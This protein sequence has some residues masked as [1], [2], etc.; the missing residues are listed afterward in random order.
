MDRTENV[1]SNSSTVIGYVSFAVGLCLLSRCI[2]V[3]V[4]SVSAVLALRC[5]VM[6]WLY[7]IILRKLCLGDKHPCIVIR[8]LFKNL[9]QRP[10]V[11]NEVSYFSLVM[12]ANVRIMLGISA[13]FGESQ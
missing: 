3:D 5:H 9:S 8:L 2:A 7:S 1:A 13:N 10:S 11:L 4:S 12:S 6:V